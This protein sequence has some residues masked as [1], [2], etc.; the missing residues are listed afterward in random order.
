M[1]LFSRFRFWGRNPLT[2]VELIIGIFSMVGGLYVIS[3]IMQYSVAVNGATP[4]ILLLSHP[5]AIAIYGAIFIISGLLIVLGVWKR[6]YQLRSWG[7][8]SNILVRMY[9]LTGTFIIQGF[10][11]LTWLS[12]LVVILIA[13]VCYVTVRGFIVRGLTDG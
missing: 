8:F 5:I 9:G 13:V 10:L 3:P 7:L 12:T 1:G 6:K 4:T 2:I 11:P